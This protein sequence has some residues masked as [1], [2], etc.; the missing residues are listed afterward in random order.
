MPAKGLTPKQRRFVAE[1]QVDQNLTKA[2]QRAGYSKR[3]AYSQGQRLLKHVEISAAIAKQADKRLDK[4]ELT[5]ERI[6][7]EIR[8]VALSSAVEFY[9]KD[10]NPK[11]LSDLTP[12]QGACLQSIETLKRNVSAGDGETETVYRI[13]LHDK[14][15]A[16]EMAAKHFALLTDVVQV[17]DVAILVASL[18]SARQSAE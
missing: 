15:K 11:P 9:D 2:A 8:R 12:E 16:L 7:E 18:Q 10:G 1:Y 4:A 14:M 17:K 13:K 6:L 5:A 3:T